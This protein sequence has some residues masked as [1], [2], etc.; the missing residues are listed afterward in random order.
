MY[1]IKTN[2]KNIVLPDKDI[3]IIAVETEKDKFVSKIIIR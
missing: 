1:I 3:Y 2:D